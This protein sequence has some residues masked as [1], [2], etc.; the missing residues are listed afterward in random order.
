[1]RRVALIIAVAALATPAPS[2]TKPQLVAIRHGDVPL[3]DVYAWERWGNFINAQAGSKTEIPYDAARLQVK[4]YPF[5]SGEIRAI[6]FNNAVRTHR[7]IN[8]TDTILYSWQAHRVQFVN[9]LAVVAGPG[10]FALHQKGVDH[11]GEEIRRGGG[12]DLEFALPFTG[13]HNDPTGRWSFAAANP[14][15]PAA[16][17]IRD[18]KPIEA[19]GAEAA[20]AP[21]GAIPYQVRVAKLAGYTARELYLP[22]GA[23]LPIRDDARDR[24]FFVLKGRVVFTTAGKDQPMEVEDAGWLASGTVGTLTAGEDAMLAE[25]MVPPAKAR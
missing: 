4:V 11:S 15:Q 24:L 3:Y 25:A 2:Q 6:R 18:G 13:M 12:I 20:A 23:R 1:M 21:A 10:D 7:H 5:P 8:L 14:I 22:A 16:T 17:W 9:K 19:I